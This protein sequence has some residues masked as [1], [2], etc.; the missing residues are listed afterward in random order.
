[1]QRGLRT[2][3]LKSKI[4]KNT[5]APLST[6]HLQHRSLWMTK[7]QTFTVSAEFTSIQAQICSRLLQG[8]KFTYNSDNKL[9]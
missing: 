2:I 8:I 3:L 6:N 9:A 1:M 5:L 7:G 4:N